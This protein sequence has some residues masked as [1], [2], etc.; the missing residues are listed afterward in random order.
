MP[1]KQEL[2]RALIN[3][4]AAGDTQ[5]ATLIANEIVAGRYDQPAQDTQAAKNPNFGALQEFMAGVNRGAVNI[6]DFLGPDQIN[7]ALQLM[8]SDKRMPTLKDSDIIQSG[9]TGPMEAGLAKDIAGT[10]GE[11]IPG[12][13]MGGQLLRSAATNLP[14]FAASSEGVFPGFIRSSGSVAPTADVLLG[15]ASGAGSE[16]GREYGGE[17]GALLGS[18]AAPLAAAR[19][20]AR[21]APAMAER[22]ARN[23]ELGD[24][25]VGGLK[26]ATGVDVGLTQPQQT[27]SRS[28][29]LKQRML[30]SLDAAS[31]KA[32]NTL[33]RQN[34][35]VYDAAVSLIDTVAPSS[36][37][38]GG[39]QR[40]KSAAEASI[41]AAKASRD[42]AVSPIYKEAFDTGASVDKKPIL[43]EIG[44][45]LKQYPEGGQIQKTLNKTLGLIDSSSDLK[46]LHGAKV[47]IDQLLAKVGDGALGNQTKRE[48]KSVKTKLLEQMD[49][50]SPAYKTAR[51]EY[52]R[53]SPAINEIEASLVGRAANISDEQIKNIS[54][55]VFDP[56]EVDPS[57]L[58]NART[59]IEAQDAGAWND[60]VR[61]GL[62]KR[63]ASASMGEGEAAVNVANDPAA[64]RRAIFG[65]GKQR[66][67]LYSAL[68][69]DQKKNFR[70]LEEVLN[71]ASAGRGAGSETAEKGRVMEELKGKGGL[72]W[73]A[74]T[75]PIKTASGGVS[76]SLFDRRV[77]TLAD[78]LLSTENAKK[79]ASIRSMGLKD[80]SNARRAL[81]SLLS[82][83]EKNTPKADEAG[84]IS[85]TE[86][87]IGKP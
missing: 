65:K 10:A 9:I 72:V 68:N 31:T 73:D 66:E 19:L 27:M 80:E 20:S 18:V 79:M 84:K 62:Q 50:S 5:A 82:E 49:A 6:A 54:N 47:E 26:A 16:V 3:A 46:Q 34:K 8:G 67:A 52:A 13:V 4:D 69:D 35:Q 59:L 1:S 7:A 21:Q 45:I 37:V 63:I 38:S 53:L 44:G 23:V 25:A 40:F 28:D 76:Q 48:L 15:A 78:A 12:A 77:S 36:S 87:G 41:K 55:L 58:K 11:F 14:K 86:N 24:K 33:E 57:V 56:A 61:V 70:W 83:I 64:L 22:A 30:P 32:L 51:E 71:R 75:S 81:V 43:D 2:E 42:E 85:E 74:I 39:R 17:P 60:I 29:L